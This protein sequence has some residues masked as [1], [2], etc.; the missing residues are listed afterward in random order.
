VRRS[1]GSTSPESWL[2]ARSQ[3]LAVCLAILLA[4]AGCRG[5]GQ[6]TTGLPQKHSVRAEQLLVQSDVK[7]PKGH[8]LLVDLEHLRRDI[9]TTLDLPV[10]EQLVT[11]YLFG[12]E[13]RYAHYLHTTYPNLPPR[14]AYFVGTAHELAVY[15]FWGEKIQEDLRHEYTHGVLH[16]CLK[17]VPLWLD[18]GL[19]EYFEVTEP[20]LGMNRDY[21]TRIS[22]SL[23]NGW[24]PDLDR[25]EQLDSVSQMQK[26]D[27]FEAWTW[28][29][30][31]LHESDDTKMV[32]L[33]YL[34]E[35]RDNPRP[36]RLT[37]RLRSVVPHADERF[38]AYTSTLGQ[39][40]TTASAS[41]RAAR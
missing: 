8:P 5:A 38:L 6:S 16:A 30:F 13:T 36:G 12:D 37:D 27:Y 4:F 3:W 40:L 17:D 19:A 2:R 22:T 11:V 20:P 18:E 1:A 34:H 25:L 41:E 28:V 10:Q 24:R 35:L 14:R 23:D 39:R 32:L 29:H 21:V 15:T 26:V 7:L 31:L 33:E 9:S